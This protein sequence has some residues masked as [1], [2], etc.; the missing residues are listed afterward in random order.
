MD[1]NYTDL[2]QLAGQT[3]EPPEEILR[4]ISERAGRDPSFAD[5]LPSLELLPTEKLRFL[6]P[7][8]WSR[9]YGIS[10]FRLGGEPAGE[11]W[12]LYRIPQPAPSPDAQPAPEAE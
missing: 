9:Y 12:G 10:Y 11:L 2:A 3:P 7:R 8:N 1:I 6:R 5:L 4:Q